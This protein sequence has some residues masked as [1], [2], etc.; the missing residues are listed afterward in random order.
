MQYNMMSLLLIP[1]DVDLSKPTI[2]AKA[3][4]FKNVI[5]DWQSLEDK[6]YFEWQEFLLHYGSYKETT[7][8]NWLDNVL[9]LSMETTLRAE[10]ESDIVS[11][12]KEQRGS[13]LHCIASS[14]GWL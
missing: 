8:N 13:I 10:V 11:I 12:P 7:S 4:H 5:D 2:V 6:D 14:G 3:R 9:L 1:Q